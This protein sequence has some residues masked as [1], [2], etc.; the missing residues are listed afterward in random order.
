[1]SD[2]CKWYVFAHNYAMDET[3]YQTLC[4]SENFVTKLDPTE[5]TFCPYCGHKLEI[6]DANARRRS[7]KLDKKS[8]S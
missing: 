6:G 5:I 1:M 4:R 8:D 7:Q 3:I 2:T